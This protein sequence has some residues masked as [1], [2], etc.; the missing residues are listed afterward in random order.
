MTPRKAWL[1]MLAMIAATALAATNSRAQIMTCCSLSYH[2]V[3]CSS[4]GCQGHVQYEACKEVDNGIFAAGPTDE[5]CCTFTEQAY[6][7]SD[8]ICQIV[9]PVGQVQKAH[10]QQQEERFVYFRSCSGS[11]QTERYVQSTRAGS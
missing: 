4:P 9:A 1:A 6:Y 11:M 8:Q 10:A 7:P 3:H 2:D 5:K